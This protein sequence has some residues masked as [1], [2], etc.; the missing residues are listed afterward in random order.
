MTLGDYTYIGSRSTLRDNVI[1]P[2]NTYVGMMSTVNKDIE[3][4][5]TYLGSPC[6]KVSDETVFDHFNFA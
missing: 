3:L 6:R 1:I 2:A 5:G 4:I